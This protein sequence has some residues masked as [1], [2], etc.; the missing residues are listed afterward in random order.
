MEFKNGAIYKN[1]DNMYWEYD[2]D[3]DD[4]PTGFISQ[5]KGSDEMTSELLNWIK[6][7]GTF[8]QINS[9]FNTFRL[10]IPGNTYFE[11]IKNTSDDR[12]RQRF[13][14]LGTNVHIMLDDGWNGKWNYIEEVNPLEEAVVK[15][16][17]RNREEKI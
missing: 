12:Y 15:S 4:G 1:I 16:I 8:E 9:K 14:I 10:E 11:K 7:Y 6:K 3:D 2:S 13:K 17:Y 5:E